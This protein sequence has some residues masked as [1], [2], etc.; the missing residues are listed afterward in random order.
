VGDTATAEALALWAH[1]PNDEC[2]LLLIAAPPELLFLVR[3]IV[4]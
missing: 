2:A 4:A 3:S 1:V